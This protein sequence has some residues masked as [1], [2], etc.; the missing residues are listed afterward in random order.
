[1]R[2]FAAFFMVL[3]V[4][5]CSGTAPVVA[6][7]FAYDHQATSIARHSAE[8]TGTRSRGHRRVSHRGWRTITARQTRAFVRQ[9]R[10]HHSG[11]GYA[12]APAD[13]RGIAWCGCWLRHQFGIANTA[14][15]LA[16]NWTK[17]GQP[18]SADDADVAVWAHHVGRVRGHR[19]GLILLESG[20]DGGGVRTRWRPIRGAIFRKV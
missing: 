15:N 5:S 3:L 10:S 8:R 2:Q 7:P 14:L 1:M 16:W 4:A 13:C 12:G 20:N 9:Y 18:A 17:V 19:D 6:R 11:R